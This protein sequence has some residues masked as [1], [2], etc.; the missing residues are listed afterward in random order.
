M[1]KPSVGTDA[2]GGGVVPPKHL[3][4]LLRHLPPGDEGP[5]GRA[6]D[7]GHGIDS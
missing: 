2:F 7:G 3:S 5:E 1:V 6:L 4:V